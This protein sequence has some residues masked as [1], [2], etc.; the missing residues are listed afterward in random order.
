[1]HYRRVIIDGYSLLH[2][3]PTLAPLLKKDLMFAREQLIKKI[4]RVASLLAEHT[5]I[6][7]DGQRGNASE[8]M[9]T[10]SLEIIFSTSD[11]TA[12]TLIERLV[13]TSS[14]PEQFLIVTSDRLERETVMA[15]GAQ[16][17]SCGEFIELCSRLKL[18]VERK[19]KGTSRKLTGPKIGD[20]FPSE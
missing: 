15:S 1:M 19:T 13:G 6:V 11:K 7:F 3:D 18:D 16:S 4:D 2:R 9:N 12:D 10:S 14:Q 5:T 20:F 8:N 17:M